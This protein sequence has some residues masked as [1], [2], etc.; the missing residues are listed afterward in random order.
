MNSRLQPLVSV[1]M[2]AHNVEHVLGVALTSVLSQTYQRLEVV[3]VD[4]GSSD[5]TREVAL[6]LSDDRIRYVRN[7]TNLG[8]FQTM[9][10]AINLARGDLVAIYHSDDIYE[11]TIVEKEVRYLQDHPEVGAVFCLD[12]YMHNDGKVF[13]G[14]TLPAEFRRKESLTYDD[15]FPFLLRNKNVLLRCP[16][17]MARREVL[18]SVGPF[19]AEGYDI[20]ADLDMWIR[21]VRRYPIGILNE[22]LMRYRVGNGQWSN[23]Y[24]RLRVEPE[25][26]FR[27]MDC[28]LEADGWRDRLGTRDLDEYAFHRCDDETF[29]A[30]NWIIRGNPAAARQLLQLGYPWQSLLRSFR[31]RKF[32][33]LLVR[34]V[35]RAGLAVGALQVTARLLKWTEYREP[36]KQW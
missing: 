34:A 1:C 24:N 32:R 18:D 27:V 10:K 6:S 31:R 28:Y 4:D 20:A 13:G 23:R 21:I 11:P 35:M 22:R 17:F 36:I 16:T 19:N 8:G 15:V 5:R 33:V 7:A 9:N 14:T 30:A 2:P 3:L 25:L 26:F 29:R 12:H